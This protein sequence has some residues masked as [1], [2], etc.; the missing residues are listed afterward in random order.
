[1][2]DFKKIKWRHYINYF[3]IGNLVA[4]LGG[5]DILQAYLEEYI[6]GT[7]AYIVSWFPAFFLGAVYGKLMDLTARFFTCSKR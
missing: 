7:A 4:V 5:M 3:I 2:M 6:G 1:M